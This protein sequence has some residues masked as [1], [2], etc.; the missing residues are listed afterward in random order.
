MSIQMPSWE[1]RLLVWAYEALE[2]HTPSEPVAADRDLLNRAYAHCAEITQ[3]HSR[4][5][6]LASA[7][8]PQD[9]RRAMRALYAF[10]RVSDD[11]VD[12]AAVGTQIDLEGWRR[13]S[14][15]SPVASPDDLVALAWADT[16]L[17]YGIPLRYAEQLLDTIARD[18]TSPRYYT[19]DELAA[20]CYGVASTVGLMAMHIIGFQSIGAFAHAIKLGVALQMTNI[21]R[22]VGEDWKAGRLYLPLDELATFGLS[23]ADIA[24]S[25]VDGRWR[26]FLSFQIDRTRRLYAE[27]M[28]GIAFLH[29]DGRFAI[30]AAGELYQA[31]LGQIEAH[32]GD[33]FH[34]RAHV[35]QWSK[36]RR[37][38]GIWWR[39]TTL[40]YR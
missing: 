39:A 21:L 31:I 29:P 5:F 28:P 4:T 35:G 27:A 13:R 34:H 40:S 1:H 26:A 25:R 20:Y 11:L 2:H 24:A 22:D 10:C 6:Y 12:R 19:F 37:L 32:N 38:P 8:L 9:K 23:E 36:L 3:A 17:R 7:L 15:S 33:V 30:A 14:L 16:R 18:V